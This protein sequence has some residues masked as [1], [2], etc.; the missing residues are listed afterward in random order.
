MDQATGIIQIYLLINNLNHTKNVNKQENIS[1]LTGEE[2]A[3][4]PLILLKPF[5]NYDVSETHTEPQ[6]T[7][8]RGQTN[9]FLKNLEPYQ[10]PDQEQ[11]KNKPVKLSDVLNIPPLTEKQKQLISNNKYLKQFSNVELLIGGK[12]CGH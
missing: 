6:I 2:I 11:L 8:M 12:Q 1:P 4:I 10:I 5:L 3:C 9:I 7:K